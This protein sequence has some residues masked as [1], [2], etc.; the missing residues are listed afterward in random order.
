MS[1]TN[2]PITTTYR[3][4]T[5]EEITIVGTPDE[6]IQVLTALRCKG[7][8]TMAI[9]VAITPE[10]IAAMRAE[11][12]AIATA[13]T[14]IHQMGADSFADWVGPLLGATHIMGGRIPDPRD[15]GPDNKFGGPTPGAFG[16]VKV[17]TK[18]REEDNA[19]WRQPSGEQPMKLTDPMD[20]FDEVLTYVN[21]T[22][23][24]LP[25]AASSEA[26]RC[27]EFLYALATRPSLPLSRS[28]PVH[29]EWI[30]LIKELIFTVRAQLRPDQDADATAKLHELITMLIVP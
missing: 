2:Q 28:N 3:H 8:T 11:L 12:E 9:P 16:G 27:L 23:R 6:V 14:E 24:H 4:G 21:N 22:R 18:P 10:D 30:A 26:T 13:Q 15:I 7:T 25:K 5:C 20:A 1:G 19:Q 17:R 29:T